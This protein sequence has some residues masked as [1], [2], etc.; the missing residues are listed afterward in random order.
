MCSLRFWQA[1]F[2]NH[3]KGTSGILRADKLKEAL[4]DVGMLIYENQFYG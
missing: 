2:K 1:I 3:T 4:H